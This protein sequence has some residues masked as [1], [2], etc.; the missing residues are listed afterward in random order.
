MSELVVAVGTVLAVVAGTL[1][2]GVGACGRWAARVGREAGE[3][4]VAPRG[5]GFGYATARAAA[6]PPVAV[7]QPP[8]P[9]R[10]RDRC[11]GPRVPRVVTHGA[12]VDRHAV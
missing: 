7:V 3:D 1:L 5:A 10:P 9:L 4:L 11:E 8:V 2:L 12:A 6:R